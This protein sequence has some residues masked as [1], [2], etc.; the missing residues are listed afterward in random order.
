MSRGACTLCLVRCCGTPVLTEVLTSVTGVHNPKRYLNYSLG[1]S[2]SVSTSRPCHPSQ[3]LA[4]SCVSKH[5]R[6]RVRFESSPGTRPYAVKSHDEIPM[7]PGLGGVQGNLHHC[8]LNVSALHCP[9]HRPAGTSSLG[10][11]SASSYDHQP[12]A[13]AHDSLTLR[14]HH[15]QHSSSSPSSPS[16]DHR[17]CRAFSG[18]SAPCAILETPVS[19]RII[20]VV[21]L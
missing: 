8:A 1:R 7:C 12:Q 2:P 10:P 11:I 13:Q 16:E 19:L 3:P 20:S 9:G 4:L 6:V 18:P 5:D 21:S 15:D 14:R 17:R